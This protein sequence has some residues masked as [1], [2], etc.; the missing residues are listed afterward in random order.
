MFSR[1]SL[2]MRRTNSFF[3][4]PFIACLVPPI[5]LW[6]RESKQNSKEA[7]VFLVTGSIALPKNRH[8]LRSLALSTGRKLGSTNDHDLPDPLIMSIHAFLDFGILWKQSNASMIMTQPWPDHDY[9]MLLH[10]NWK[11]EERIYLSATFLETSAESRLFQN[12]TLESLPT[13]IPSRK[14]YLSFPIMIHCYS[15]ESLVK[16]THAKS[17]FDA[18]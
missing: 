6:S 13:F 8:V 10:G 15:L 9:V 5:H 17:S 3:Q 4:L 18:N 16:L 14:I 1:T 11:K 12:Q 2:G 7:Q